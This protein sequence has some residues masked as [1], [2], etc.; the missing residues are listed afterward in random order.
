MKTF[1]LDLLP[2]VFTAT[3]GMFFAAYAA[4]AGFLLTHGAYRAYAS[5]AARAGVV[6]LAVTAVTAC[7]YV[8]IDV[9]WR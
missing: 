6:S 9:H 4:A 5:K 2:Y 7:M 1:I 8:V 3:T